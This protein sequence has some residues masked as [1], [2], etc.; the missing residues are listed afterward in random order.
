MER[1]LA[2]IDFSGASINA[3]EH[4][5]VYANFLKTHLRMVFVSKKKEF[6]T[7]FYFMEEEMQNSGT[8][9][10][11][12]KILLDKLSHKYNVPEGLFDFQILKGKVYAELVELARGDSDILIMMGTHGVSGFEEYI[13]GS[14]VVIKAP[15]PVITIRHGFVSGPIRKIVLPIDITNQSRQKVPLVTELAEAFDAEIHVLGVHET[16]GKDLIARI[17]QYKDQVYD[18][19]EI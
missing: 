5:I 12:F 9:E 11:Y 15:C 14:K 1:I 8:T 3:L 17:N 4:A 19:I 10:D 18:F 16:D 13:M 7:S 6:E 2:A